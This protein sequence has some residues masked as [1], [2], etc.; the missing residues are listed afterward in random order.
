M[1]KTDLAGREYPLEAFVFGEL[2]QRVGSIKKAWETAVLKAHGVAPQWVKRKLTT[3]CREHLRRIDLPF[4]DLRR[5]AA[6]RWHEGGFSLHEVRDLLGDAHVS[7]TDTYLGAKIDGL[8]TKMDR[9]D[10]QRGNL[11]Q[12][13][14]AIEHR[15][16]SHGG[17]EK[18]RKDQLH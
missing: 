13:P 7:Q 15:P 17:A 12:T 3:E 2:G 10:A 1:A 18:Q 16:L 9:F 6:S 5:E 4:H 8:R 11:S 14:P